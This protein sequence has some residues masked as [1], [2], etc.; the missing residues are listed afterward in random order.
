[1]KDMTTGKEGR[2]ILQFALPM[3]AGSL[4]QQFYNIVDSIIVGNFIGK[5]A[6]AAVGASFPVIF[7]LISMI[8]GLGAGITVVI[9]QY[10]GAKDYASV[11]KAIDTMYIGM[12]FASIVVTI[13]GLI[14]SEEI[15][16]LLNLPEEVMPMALEYLNIYL[17]GIVAFFI[18][19]GTSAILRGMGDSKT[20]LYF[21]ILSTLTNV[22]LDLLFV[23]VFNMG[24][25]GVALATVIAQSGALVTA[26]IYLNHYHKI[27]DI[28]LRGLV[29]DR[30]IFNQSIRIGLPTG[31][32]HSF[33]AL[34]SMAIM[35]VVN[36]FGTN[37]IAAFSVAARLDAI[38]TIPA[39]IMSQALATFVG[40]NL[41]AN[42]SHRVK[43]GLLSTILLTGIV[44]IATTAIIISFG[45]LF[46]DAFTNDP[47]VIE[48]GSDYLTIVSL[49]YIVFAF[50]FTFNGVMRG[51]GDTVIP[52]I[53]TLISL[54]LVRI[55]FAVFLSDR[56]GETG[57]WWSYPMS[58][59]MGLIM[60]WTYYL[61]G[62]WKKKVIV[63]PRLREKPDF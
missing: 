58:W 19:N 32:Q 38:A 36:T 59:V 20:P 28:K 40:Q 23:V 1:M 48:I 3:L 49:F 43:T 17:L 37:V 9:S 14:F 35:G 31:F 33:V 10:F 29:F 46:M 16:V 21:L 52:M 50:M 18:F 11:R 57:I 5:E 13:V 7:V 62:R 44:T 42:K 30:K 25:K 24:V 54:W 51:A 61:T 39:M 56:F 4:F 34:G 26:I 53:F 63:K 2:Q 12:F 47:D 41:G 27:I 55:P 6:L 45:D 22:G 8:I 60:S 15:F